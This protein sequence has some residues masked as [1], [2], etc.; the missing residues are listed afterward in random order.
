LLAS[1]DGGRGGPINYQSTLHVSFENFH[2]PVFI[3]LITM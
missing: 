2:L 1:S 3:E